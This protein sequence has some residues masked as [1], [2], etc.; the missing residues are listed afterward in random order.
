MKR[1]EGVEEAT[2]SYEL[3]EGQV[4]YDPEQTNPGAIIAELERMTGFVGVVRGDEDSE[5]E[6]QRQ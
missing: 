5:G 6:S 3:S 2:F 4:T 1:V